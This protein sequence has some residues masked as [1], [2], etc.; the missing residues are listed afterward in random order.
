MNKCLTS[1]LFLLLAAICMVSCTS[2]TRYNQRLATP[3]SVVKL[4]KDINYIERKLH[5]LYPNLNGYISNDQLT[6]KFDSIRK[7]VNQPMTAKEFYFVIAPVIASVRQ[8]HMSTAWPQPLATKAQRKY[9]KKM[10]EGPL[11]QF[12]T[13][14]IDHKMIVLK[15]LSDKKALMPGAEIVTVNGITPQELFT[16]YR[17]T[18]TSDG[19]NETYIRRGFGKRLLTYFTGELGLQDSLKIVVK[20]NDSI[21]SMIVKRK[22]KPSKKA[23]DKYN[24]KK[25]GKQ[26][27]DTL[28]SKDTLSKTTKKE[29]QFTRRER[30]IFN[31]DPKNKEFSVS[32]KKSIVDTSLYILRIKNFSASK[33]KKAYTIIFD[34][35]KK[36]KLDGLVLDLRDNPGG[37]I[38]DA[39]NLYRHFI[40]QETILLQPS[41]V[42]SKTSLWKIGVLQNL[43]PI[44]YPFFLAG[45]PMYMG[46]SYFRTTK[47]PKGGY[48]YKLVGSRIIKPASNAYLGK[49]YVLI[50]GGS[51]SAACIEAVALKNRPNT[52]FVGEETGGAFNGTVAGIM[53]V[54]RLPHSKI[55]V[56]LGLMHIQTVTQS[57]IKGRGIFPDITIIPTLEDRVKARDPEM[58]YVAKHKRNSAVSLQQ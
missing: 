21:Y 10:G 36:M 11:S 16:K 54:I 52:F 42:T 18:L 12:T 57:E 46:F 23:V 50:N 7:V 43:S 3:I 34:S 14:W 4:Q 47:R 33:H 9:Y 25:L 56:R 8:G 5:R 28:K 26:P 55:S 40:D 38:A 51:F 27:K 53:P 32:L 20:Q 39:V 35:I 22:V 29:R 19:F 6:S 48:Q 24:E 49:L 58:E 45:Y 41:E 31:W 13:E 15:N 44:G 37:R 17:P 1:Y 30:R 2:V